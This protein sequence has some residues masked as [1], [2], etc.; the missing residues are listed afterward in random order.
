M[1]P[2]ADRRRLLIEGQTATRSTANEREF[3]DA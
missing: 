2:L 3:G 1:A